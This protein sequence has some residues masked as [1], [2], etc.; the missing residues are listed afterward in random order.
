MTKQYEFNTYFKRYLREIVS[1][2]VACALKKRGHKTG[3][4]NVEWVSST[5]VRMIINYNL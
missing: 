5:V 3:R 1:N 2:T 4:G